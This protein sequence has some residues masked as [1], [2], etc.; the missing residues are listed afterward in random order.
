MAANTGQ[1]NSLERQEEDNLES[2]QG[3][4][5]LL[6]LMGEI[7]CQRKKRKVELEA[8]SCIC[9]NKIS[10]LWWRSKSKIN[11]TC[12]TKEPVE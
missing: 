4:P 6:Q 3:G 5:V 1:A 2:S 11:Y 9:T 12:Q 7:W 10:Y 8:R